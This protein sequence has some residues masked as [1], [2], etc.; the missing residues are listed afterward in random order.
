MVKCFFFHF[1]GYWT[2]LHTC[3]FPNAHCSM[4]WQ[5]EFS[6]IAEGQ[7]ELESKDSVNGVGNNSQS[8]VWKGEG[9]FLGQAAVYANWECPF[10]PLALTHS[11]TP[12]RTLYTNTEINTTQIFWKHVNGFTAVQC[13][14]ANSHTT[15]LPASCLSV[16]N[17]LLCTP[18][19]IKCV[20]AFKYLWFHSVLIW[21]SS[22]YLWVCTELLKP[23]STSGEKKIKR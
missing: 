5:N 3:F 9:L 14:Q 13:R 21:L 11:H 16:L 2:D 1:T 10:P 4:T 15:D 6:S 23:I 18:T 22:L 20:K 8:C 12:C 19:G 7:R 17:Y